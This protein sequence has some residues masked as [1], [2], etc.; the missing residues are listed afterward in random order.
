MMPDNERSRLIALT[1]AATIVLVLAGLLVARI[2]STEVGASPPPQAEI[3]APREIQQVDLEIPCWSCPSARSWP[4]RFQTDLD[5]LAPLGNGPKNAATFFSLFEKER[6]PRAAESS[7]FLEKRQTIEGLEDYGASVPF[8]EP[9]LIEAEPWVDQAKMHFYPGVFPIEGSE[10]RLPNLLVMLA[11]GRTWTGRGVL[12]EDPVAGLE[13][14][15]RAIRL[16]RL[17]RQEDAI[18]INDLVGLAC[19]HIGTRGIYEIAQRTG[20]T[21]LA[22]LASIVIG[23]VAPQRLN[24]SQQVTRADLTPFVRENPDGSYDLEAS[25][26]VVDA[27][28]EMATTNSDH[29]FRGEASIGGLFTLLHFGTPEQQ[30]KARAVLVEMVNGSDPFFA[31]IGQWCLEEPATD[32]TLAEMWV[33]FNE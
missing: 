26:K 28:I 19:I 7:L 17:L 8:D 14:C 11:M 21:E 13:D 12:A 16:G 2:T 29:R 32:E 3:P 15:R 23:E 20:D 18:L 10:T 24:T 22:L 5:L 4:L 31:E 27:I 9:M 30:L 25:D 1:A 6:G 33:L